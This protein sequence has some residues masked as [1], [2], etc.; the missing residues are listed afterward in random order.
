[1]LL[2]VATFLFSGSVFAKRKAQAPVPRPAKH[3]IVKDFKDLNLDHM[4]SVCYAAR[5]FTELDIHELLKLR[6][7]C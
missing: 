1:M 6:L 3:K 2:V 5:D 7:P 4:L